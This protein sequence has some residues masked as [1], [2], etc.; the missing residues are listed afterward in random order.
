MTSR[1]LIT[2]VQEY[3]GKYTT[4]IPM[5]LINLLGIKKGDTFV[6]NLYEHNI[7]RLHLEKNKYDKSI[8]YKD[9]KTY[10]FYETLEMQFKELLESMVKEGKVKKTVVGGIEKYEVI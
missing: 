9:G 4:P 10:Y 6:W 7:I 2:T 1:G 3:K 8:K 5:A